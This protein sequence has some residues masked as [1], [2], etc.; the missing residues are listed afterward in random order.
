LK[1]QLLNYT[2]NNQYKW[3]SLDKIRNG[4]A[5]ALSIAAYDKDCEAVVTIAAQAFVEKQTL[6]GI[7]IAKKNFENL[8]QMEKL[9]KWHGDKA[10]WV[11][12]AWT[13]T[14]LCSGFRHWQLTNI[15]QVYCP[16]L[17]IHGKNDEYGSVAFP[18]YIVNNASGNSQI[19]IIVDCGHMPHK[20]HT[21]QVLSVIKQFTQGLLGSYIKNLD[22]E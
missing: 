19:E 3:L 8:K 5:M 11:L 16:V 9:T 13:E 4:G 12:K 2:S 15:K 10:E 21:E 7:Q 22:K 6:Q 1:I 14:W 18:E 17:A 20:S